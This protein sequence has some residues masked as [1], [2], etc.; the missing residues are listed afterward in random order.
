MFTSSD[1]TT[2]IEIQRS[3]KLLQKLKDQ[4]SP[5]TDELSDV[6]N[7]LLDARGSII[8][9]LLDDELMSFASFDQDLRMVLAKRDDK[10]KV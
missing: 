7:T 8:D 10:K 5:H 1:F 3:L 2:L 9:K 4:K 6:W